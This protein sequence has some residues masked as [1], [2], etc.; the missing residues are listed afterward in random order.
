[1]HRLSRSELIV[2]DGY[3]ASYTL[4]G[5]AISTSAGAGVQFRLSNN[6]I[7]SIS[8]LRQIASGKS[9][10]AVEGGRIYVGDNIYKL[11]DNVQIVDISDTSQMKGIT[12]DD[13]A[14]MLSA[15]VT[16]YSDKADGIIRVIT[17]RK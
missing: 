8:P 7:S 14:K 5:G 13:L 12:V 11:S 16:L 6:M 2:S 9:V 17:V 15:T 3:Q 1:M 4:S 10:K